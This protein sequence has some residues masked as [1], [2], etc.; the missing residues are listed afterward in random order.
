LHALLLDRKGQHGDVVE[1]IQSLAQLP[2]H[3][4]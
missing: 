4:V 2:G 1:R 3:V